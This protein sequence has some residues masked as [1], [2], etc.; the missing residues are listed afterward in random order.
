MCCAPLP[1]LPDGVHVLRPDVDAI[2][3]AGKRGADLI[4][5]L[6]AVGRRPP[7]QP[8]VISPAGVIH[9]LAPILRS[10]VPAAI[11][12]DL[13]RG[14][15]TGPVRVDRGELERA[16]VN[17]VLNARDAMAG[18]GRL[19]IS[20]EPASLSV[21][22]PRLGPSVAPG[23]FARITVRDSGSGIAPEAM[24]HIF[25]PFFTT[26][27]PG[28]GAGLGLSSVEGFVEVSG[29]FLDVESLVG[30]GSAFSI[31]L[32]VVT[33]AIPVP[34]P[35]IRPSLA[36]GSE[37]ILLVDDE[38]NVRGVTARL[39]R[40]LGYEVLEATDPGS[41]LRL[42]GGGASFDLLLT[43]VVMPGMSGGELSERLTELRPGLPTLF[44]SGY[45]PE[46]PADDRLASGAADYLAKP[47]DRST[48]AARVRRLLDRAP[49][50]D[51]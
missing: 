38:S 41:A 15:V 11:D 13:P 8:V 23:D 40:S 12:L 36:G 9:D 3:E 43:D 17:L 5:Q 35:A 32:P 19:A 29:G 18:T 39:L 25:D 21:G 28:A 20:L 16:I 49:A 34:V 47:F 33:D 37:T 6:L 30:T 51:S 10:L 2:R 4:R 7:L 26:K 27:E 44:I 1:G 22:D 46:V 24:A 42:A 14:V 50:D 48:L 45:A 31:H